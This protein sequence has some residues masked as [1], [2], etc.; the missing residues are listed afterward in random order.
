MTHRQDPWRALLAAASGDQVAARALGLSCGS[1]QR[2]RW[3]EPASSAEEDLWSVYLPFLPCAGSQG[4]SCIIGH[5]GQSLDGFIATQTGDSRFVTGPDNIIHLH[6]MR[7][8]ADA[9][10]V[11]AGTVAIDDPRLT[12]RL[13]PGPSPVRVVLD[14]EARV[15]TDRQLFTDGCAPTL[16]CR[17]PGSAQRFDD[18]DVE[19]VEVPAARGS[20][21]GLDLAAVTAALRARGLSRLFVEGGGVTVSQFLQQGLLDRLQITVAPLIIGAGRRGLTLPATERLADALRPAHQRYPMGEDVLFDCDLRANRPL[22][23]SS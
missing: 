16:L 3:S 19:L 2:W 13:V 6:R 8:L 12:T 10:L 5:L 7:A 1:D 17:R 15:P 9:V 14:P 18:A 20:A 4:R 22:L 23:A 11:G 21:V